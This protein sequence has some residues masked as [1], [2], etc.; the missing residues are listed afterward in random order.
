MATERIVF[1]NLEDKQNRIEGI[2]LA[3]YIVDNK[4]IANFLNS[5]GVKTGSGKEITAEAISYT[6]GI[7]K[8][9]QFQPLGEEPI[10]LAETVPPISIRAAALEIENKNWEPDEI[11]EIMFCTSY[12]FDVKV[13]ELIAASLHAQNARTRDVYTAC[14]GGARAL[15]ELKYVESGAKILIVAAEA[16]STVLEKNDLDRAIFSDG[17]ATFAFDTEKDF[18]IVG[19]ITIFEPSNAITLPVNSDLIPEGSVS[20]NMEYSD[21]FRQNGRKVLKWVRT[22]T[23]K[24]TILDAYQNAQGGT[25]MVHVVFHQGSGRM[26]SGLR[27]DLA[28]EGIPGEFITPGTV[29][30]LGNLGAASVIADFRSYTQTN[31]IRQ[32][33]HI[34]LSGFGAGLATSTVI[35]KANRDIG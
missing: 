19:G 6:T 9:A 25:S 2:V 13:S 5:N 21:Y 14:S 20:E 26:V 8:R 18:E 22:G 4:E 10:P 30:D 34:I 28:K 15:E 23:P 24:R 7:E 16:Y 11:D 29:Q 12:P 31:E 1:E 35:L 27:E 17:A 33:D 32:D 3:P